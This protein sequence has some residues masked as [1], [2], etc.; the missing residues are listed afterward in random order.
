MGD[1]YQSIVVD[2][3]R[4]DRSIF[5]N[6]EC[7]IQIH[8]GPQPPKG[9]SWYCD[10]LAVDFESDPSDSAT[11][12]LC[13]VTFSETLQSLIKRLKDWNVH[14]QEIR[15]ALAR[16]SHLP[17]EWQVRPWLFVP[18]AKNCAEKLVH[19][20]EDIDH[21]QQLSFNPRITTLEMVVPWQY[22]WD[23]TTENPKPD[24]IPP[25]WRV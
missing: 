19:A 1:Y 2:Y 7:F 22:S 13:E 16:Y 8:P 5:V 10:V 25:K 14:W 6:P 24:C 15:K 4:A 17:I 11:V 9:S 18:E 12:F 3:L 20:L 23:R 21:C